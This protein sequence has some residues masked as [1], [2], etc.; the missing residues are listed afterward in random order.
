MELLQ[1]K[2]ELEEK[3]SLLAIKTEEAKTLIEARDI[4][5]AKELKEEINGIQKELTLLAERVAELEIE[6][7]PEQEEM[8][9]EIKEEV[10]IEA[11]E[12]DSN[13]KGDLKTMENRQIINTGDYAV[14][15]RNAFIKTLQGKATAEERALVVTSTDAD[16][17]YLVPATISTQ[18]NELKRNYKSAK[19]LVDVIRTSTQAGSFVVEEGGNVTE[20]VNFDENTPGLDEQA[21]TFKNVEYKVASYGSITPI[22][23]TFLQDEDASFMTYLNRLFS[24]KAVKTENVK[25]FA[26]LK[27]G[28]GT[29]KK[30]KDIKDVKNLFNVELDASISANAVVI[31]NQTGFQYLDAMEDKNGRGLLQDNPAD[32]TQ[33]LLQGRIVHVFSNAELANNVKKAPIYIGD[34]NEAVKFFDRGAYEVAI[35]KEAGF[36]KNQTVARVVERFDTIVADKDAYVYGEIDEVVIPVI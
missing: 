25:I 15:E 24:K 11:E 7:E 12:R 18:I 6:E 29:S 35:S 5:G 21:P 4:D 28:G 34:L 10:E 2:I 33:K 8:E 20:L 19:D 1:A 16:G 22:S 3:R 14:E 27:A 9:E 30:I 31:T 17:G 32:A 26:A 13:K 36:A 23:N